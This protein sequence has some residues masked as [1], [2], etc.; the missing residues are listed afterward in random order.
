[1][2]MADIIRARGAFGYDPQVGIDEEIRQTVASLRDAIGA[3][4]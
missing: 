3:R 2:T 1:M 4:A